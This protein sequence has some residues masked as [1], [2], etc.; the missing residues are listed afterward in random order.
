MQNH[1]QLILRASAFA[2]EYHGGQYRK[3]KKA[4]PYITH[5]LEVSRVLSE[6][7]GIEDVEVLAAAI[8][9][10]TI[11][12]T[13]ASREDISKRFGDRI[14][15]MVLELTDDKH[16]E[17]DDRK[18]MQVINAPGKS[19]GA[20][21]IKLADKIA[22]VRDITNSPPDW[23]EERKADYIAW[24]NKVVDALPPGNEQ[25]RAIFA[26]AVEAFHASNAQSGGAK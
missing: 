13:A 6:E 17:K 1:I 19:P 20:A 25:L 7:G 14:C 3:G 11:E 21:A 26:R 16:L 23:P 15:G 9:H 18:R 2:A 24:A 12:D 8:L 22:N 4:L 10:D 5:P